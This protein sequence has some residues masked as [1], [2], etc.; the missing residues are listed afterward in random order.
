MNFWPIY[1]IFVGTN[2]SIV[3]AS[4]IFV[5]SNLNL[6]FLASWKA[7]KITTLGRLNLLEKVD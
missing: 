4:N 1:I 6:F 5:T 2:F 3:N 7:K